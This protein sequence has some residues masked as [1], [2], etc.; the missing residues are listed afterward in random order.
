[1][2]DVRSELN[3]AAGRRV[4][5]AG[6]AVLALTGAAGGAMAADAAGAAASDKTQLDELVVTARG[7]VPTTDVSATK[8][9]IPLVE[10]PQSVTVVTRD[11][12]NVLNIQNLQQAMRYSAG[13]VG[14]NFG[15]D[16]RFDW[17]T[18]RGFSP[19]EYIDGLQAPV[20]S[21]GS[22]GLDLWDAESVEI[23][24]G[25]SGVLYGQTPPGGIVNFT[26]RRP[27]ADFAAEVQ[28][29]YGSF[30]HKQ[31]AGTITGKLD[32]SDTF[33]GS[34]TALWRDHDTQLNYAH[35]K[36]VMIA[37]ALTWNIDAGTHF[38]FLSYY[39]HDDARGGDGGFLPEVGTLLPNPNGQIPVNFNPG[40]PGYNRFKRA[41]Y[42]I[43]YQ[44]D[45]AF[46]D[47]I[48]FVQNLKYSVQDEHFTSIYGNGLEAD[49]RTLDRADFLFPE[50]IKS[51]AVDSRLQI[52]ANTGAIEHTV[53]AGVDFREV[54]NHTQFYFGDAPSI[55]LYNPVYGKPIPATWFN[56]PNY[57]NSD[58]T[59]TGIY[60]QDSLKWNHWR[61]T[62][63]IRNDWLRGDVNDSAFTYR[64]GLNYLFD[65]GLAPYVAYA[66]SFLPT[67][68]A[69]FGG[70]AFKP[71]SGSQ[72]EG[73]V[74]FEPH[75]LGR[76]TKVF[77]TAAGYDLVQD[78]VLTSDP[79]H[80]FFSLQTGQVEV[81]G[82]EFE[83]VARVHERLTINASYSYTN[84]VVTRSN[85]VGA[86]GKQVTN[87]PKFK[88][89]LLVD[90]TQ[91]TGP[92]AGLG[93]GAGIRYLGTSF[94]D[95]FN[96]LRAPPET[97]GDLIA[98]YDYR[99]WR[100]A[101]NVSNIADKVYVARCTSTAACYY[102]SRREV[103]VSLDRKW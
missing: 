80:A 76:D 82:A 90:Y 12:I 70:H 17:L 72:I 52:K 33:E 43:G 71:S 23:L 42:G 57:I 20:G 34:L 19:V 22:V 11:Q 6:A 59:Q 49:N 13:A 78:N 99:K 55:D 39:Q 96:T 73:G 27:H 28:G 21:V 97:L 95:E 48:S 47:H 46:N 7:Y 100:L 3:F 44:F 29:Q 41:L 31:I 81:T 26:S 91:Q 83:A 103:F 93:F 101:V 32:A 85:D 88:A 24:K 65:I 1:M 16:E 68:G 8:S 62:A 64:V 98:H 37:P 77:I 38:T 67:S 5:L 36:R 61:L 25:P 66:T 60:A 63:S 35:S 45:H 75:N 40:E 94:G 2:A 92:L 56:S 10:T 51:L 50:Y 9:A 4:L 58:N 18:L 14:E 87:V 102:S 15:P 79:N 54:W 86:T 74:K 84:A 30:D 69:D 53:L 89:S